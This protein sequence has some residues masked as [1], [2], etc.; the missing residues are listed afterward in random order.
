VQLLQ[1]EHTT[2]TRV[3]D[4]FASPSIELSEFSFTQVTELY[5]L[6]P[7]SWVLLDSQ[8]TVLVF[9]NPSFLSNIRRSSNQLKVYTN[10]GTQV[11]SLIGNI[12]NFG[13]V[14]YNPKLLANIFS[15][16]AVRK[17]C[18]ITMDSNVEPA[19]CVHLAN[20]SVMKFSEYK[21]DLYYHDAA[22]A[23]PKTNVDPVIDYSFVTTVIDNKKLFTRREI[24]GAN[25]ARELSKKNGLL[26]NNSRKFSSKISFATAPSPLTTPNG[27]SLSTAPT[28]LR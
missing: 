15:L 28:L 22:A 10:G 3:I 11:S 17:L 18:R 24:E 1:A 7:S 16:A 25:K 27:H 14:W 8:F 13:T 12:K 26:N 20:G 6:I 21:T 5:K 4:D 9:K 2:D 19:L 23:A